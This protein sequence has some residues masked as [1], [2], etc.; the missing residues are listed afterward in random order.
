MYFLEKCI[1]K[2]CTTVTTKICDRNWQ[3]IIFIGINY[4]WALARLSHAIYLFIVV[5]HGAHITFNI[6]K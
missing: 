2:L 5:F 4:S 1:A 3:Y 6:S